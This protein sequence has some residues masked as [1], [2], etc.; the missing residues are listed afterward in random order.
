MGNNRYAREVKDGPNVVKMKSPTSCPSPTVAPKQLPVS[1][2]AP[3]PK[4]PKDNNANSSSPISN[5]IFT[6][7][8]S[9]KDSKPQQKENVSVV[10][11]RDRTGP[12]QDDRRRNRKKGQEEQEEE[13][14]PRNR[15]EEEV[16]RQVREERFR[17]DAAESGRNFPELLERAGFS[18]TPKC[19]VCLSGLTFA[20]GIY[21]LCFV[22]RCDARPN[23]CVLL[24]CRTCVKKGVPDFKSSTRNSEFAWMK[25]CPTRSCTSEKLSC[26]ALDLKLLSDEDVLLKLSR[27]SAALSLQVVPKD[28]K[29]TALKVE[30]G[31]VFK[32]KTAKPSKPVV[33]PFKTETV[34][35]SPE[36]SPVQ[37]SE[38]PQQ[39]KPLSTAANSLNRKERRALQRRAELKRRQSDSRFPGQREF[40]SF[41]QLEESEEIG[42][43]LNMVFYSQPILELP[44]L[45][46]RERE[47]KSLEP[48]RKQ[49]L[50]NRKKKEKRRRKQREKENVLSF[51]SLQA[52]NDAIEL[53]ESSPQ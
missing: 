19:G 46:R 29:P 6:A 49:T 4:T 28:P 53:P 38:T 31:L 10:N 14:G 15:E 51:P 34:P 3:P 20:R 41:A 52:F 11:Q 26:Q 22:A 18:K 24:V 43:F 9:P 5:P 48:T 39:I 50:K 25:S 21:E 2:S 30:E 1:A 17:R 16:N 8:N 47:S 12:V 7:K 33:A 40:D 42:T 27:S 45:D 32:K 35:N 13:S 36:L 44:S 37:I 23:P